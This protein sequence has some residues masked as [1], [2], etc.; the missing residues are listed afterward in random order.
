[1]EQGGDRSECCLQAPS[2]YINAPL[3]VFQCFPLLWF[4]FRLDLQAYME[5]ARPGPR[6]CVCD[7]AQQPL[8]HVFLELGK[9]THVFTYLGFCFGVCWF[10]VS[11]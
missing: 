8:P 6:S 9:P 1:M 10:P 11:S 7:L 5:R 2:L 3:L 4:S